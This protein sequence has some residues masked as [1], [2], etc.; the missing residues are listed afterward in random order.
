MRSE[1]TLSELLRYSRGTPHERRANGRAATAHQVLPGPDARPIPGPLNH[2]LHFATCSLPILGSAF[3]PLLLTFYEG[4]PS[5]QHAP[6]SNRAAAVPAAPI[7]GRELAPR[8]TTDDARNCADLRFV[9]PRL[10]SPPHHRGT[11]PSLCSII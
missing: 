6:H 1:M 11:I 5:P 8:A 10:P 9:E 4:S 3:S 7:R 2:S